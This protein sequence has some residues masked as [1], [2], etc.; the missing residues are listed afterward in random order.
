[1][2]AIREP[3][4]AMHGLAA[5]VVA[6]PLANLDQKMATHKTRTFP[7]LEIEALDVIFRHKTVPSCGRR[8][9]ASHTMSS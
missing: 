9:I 2:F 3:D 8:G 1:M 7:K 6:M 5:V 4:E